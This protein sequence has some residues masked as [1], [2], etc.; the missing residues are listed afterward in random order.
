MRR[1]LPGNCKKKGCASYT[2]GTDTHQVL[3]DVTP[4]GLDGGKAEKALESAGIVLNQN[5][6]PGR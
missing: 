4:R 6:I 5:V 1:I 3:V 2:G